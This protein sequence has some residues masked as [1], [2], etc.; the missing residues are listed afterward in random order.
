MYFINSVIIGGA[1]LSEDYF[2]DRQDR[3]Y[4]ISDCEPLANYYDDL[5]SISNSFLEFLVVYS[6]WLFI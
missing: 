5:I 3:S 4:I 2:T 6:A 1:N